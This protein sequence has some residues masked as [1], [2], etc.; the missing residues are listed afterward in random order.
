MRVQLRVGFAARAVQVRGD[1]WLRALAL[2]PIMPTARDKKLL[3]F[4]K[5]KR[6]LNGARVCACSIASRCSG[7]AMPHTTETDFGAENVRSHPGRCCSPARCTRGS[8]LFG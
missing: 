5:A 8:P 6:A 7:S 2:D 4:G 1:D 3:L